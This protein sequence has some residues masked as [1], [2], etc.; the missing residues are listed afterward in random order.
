MIIL[1]RSE[2]K[3]DVIDK[4]I[5]FTFHLGKISS[6]IIRLYRCRSRFGKTNSISSRR[7]GYFLRTLSLTPT[8]VRLLDSQDDRLCATIIY[9]API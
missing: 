3:F 7:C 9:F 6:Y 5:A 8:D 2:N 4:I 1:L